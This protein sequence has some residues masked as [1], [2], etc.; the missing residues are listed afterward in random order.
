MLIPW[1]SFQVSEQ[2]HTLKQ[3]VKYS[4]VCV[5]GC[6]CVRSFDKSSRVTLS[7]TDCTTHSK[8]K[9]KERLNRYSVT[10]EGLSEAATRRR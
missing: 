10:D 9:K 8:K 1:A 2:I 4:G 7:N 5:G 6:V 3:Q